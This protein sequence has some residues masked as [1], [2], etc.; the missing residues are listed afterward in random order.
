[1][2]ITLTNRSPYLLIVPLNSGT[3]L[4]LAPGQSSGTVDDLEVNG[5][6]KVEK[7]VNN[8]QLSTQVVKHEHVAE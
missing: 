4:H 2:E 6:L 8:C 7:L 5:N 3:T 1:M